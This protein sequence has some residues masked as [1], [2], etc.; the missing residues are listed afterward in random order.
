M[1]KYERDIGFS[2][3]ED[4]LIGLADILIDCRNYY[5]LLPVIYIYLYIPVIYSTS[6]C[7]LHP[8]LGGIL[9]ELQ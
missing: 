9:I 1:E 3:R 7:S 8:T 4:S 5:F 2:A 6:L